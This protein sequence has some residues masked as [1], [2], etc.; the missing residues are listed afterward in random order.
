MG[1]HESNDDEESKDG[2]ESDEAGEEV[3]ED[4][5]EE[6]EREPVA[7]QREEW[8]VVVEGEEEGKDDDQDKNNAM[9]IGSCV[10]VIKSFN[11]TGEGTR[12]QKGWKGIVE[13]IDGD[14]NAFIGFC[15]GRK[16]E[17]VSHEDFEELSKLEPE[18]GH[19]EKDAAKREEA[20]AEDVDDEDVADETLFVSQRAMASI[21]GKLAKAVVPTQAD[22]SKLL[23]TTTFAEDEELVSL[24]LSILG[25]PSP[26]ALS[27]KQ[28][29][30][31]WTATFVKKH[32]LKRAAELCLKAELDEE[33]EDN[34]EEAEEEEEEE[35]EEEK[36][37]DVKVE[38]EAK[39]TDKVSP[40]GV[41]NRV[42]V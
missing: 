38:E 31:Q 14:G 25:I 22:I 19:E 9:S 3:H 2:E 10:E 26:D 11:L 35:D 34:E 21:K 5:E 29:V 28:A 17:W 36:H 24:D 12:L 18:K 37:E 16:G 6:I 1:G 40:G 41:A 27:S 13:E 7:K 4:E 15:D 32:G 42:K 33:D 39:K 8:K 23:D 30:A 20:E